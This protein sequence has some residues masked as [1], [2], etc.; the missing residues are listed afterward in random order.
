MNAAPN[1]ADIAALMGDPARAAILSALT[2]GRALTATELSLEAGVTPQTTSSHLAKLTDAG[3]LRVARQGR[4]RYYRLAGPEVAQLL[5]GL[6]VMAGGRPQ[7][8]RA[9]NPKMDA[10]RQARTCYD[11]FAGR[12]GVGL[13]RALV[14]G[15]LLEAIGDDFELTLAGE[16]RMGAFGLDLPALRRQRRAFARQCLDWSE[17]E[18]H[19]AGALGAGVADRCFALGWVARPRPGRAV[20]VTERGRRGLQKAFSLR[21]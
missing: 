1:F 17:R 19:L 2:A 18:P 10:V 7:R 15:G 5:E 11:H 16:D 6:M 12:L 14:D 21:L 9:R 8:P 3:L 20:T 4:H 13:T